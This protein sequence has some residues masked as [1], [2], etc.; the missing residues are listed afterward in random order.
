M[1]NTAKSGDTV[2]LAHKDTSFFDPR[3]E[4][5]VVR[6]GTAKLGKTIGN[7]TTTALMSGR[8]LVVSGGKSK[9]EAKGENSDESDLP[10]DFPGRDAFVA[11]DMDFYKVK[12]FDFETDK[13][14]GVGP[15][16]I[17]AVADYFKK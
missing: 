12:N 10:N 7:K 4:L 8:L 6:D 1:S 17:K 2:E 5:K 16:T 11:A 13:V 15:A 14:S 3:T 9:S